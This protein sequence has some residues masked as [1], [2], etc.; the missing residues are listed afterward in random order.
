MMRE[1]LVLVDDQEPGPD[2]RAQQQ[3]QQ[4]QLVLGGGGGGGGGER[5]YW[6][7]ALGLDWGTAQYQAARG[8]SGG[9]GGGGE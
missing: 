7:P 4:Q 3:Q 9:G 6:V 1:G 8:L 5:L 2:P